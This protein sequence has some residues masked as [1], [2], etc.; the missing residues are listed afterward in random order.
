MRL[1]KMNLRLS[2]VCLLLPVSAAMA[3]PSLL[4]EQAVQPPLQVSLELP[5]KKLLR[6]RNSNKEG[7]DVVTG[8]FTLLPA[9]EQN[10]FPVE[11][12]IRGKSRR[13][14][15]RFPPLRLTFKKSDVKGS[16]LHGQ[17][18]LKLVTHCQENF[19]RR[20][21]LAA[22]M[23]AYRTLN[24]LTDM[25]FRVVA[26][27]ITYI[28][29][30]SGDETVQHAFL[31]EHKNKLAKRLQTDQVDVQQIKRGE[32]DENYAALVSMFQLL[33]GNTDFSLVSGPPE[34]ECCH[35][36]VVLQNP[37]TQKYHVVP[38]DFD[39]TGLVNP[40]YT[41]PPE[42]LGIKRFTQRKYRGY[43]LH[44][45]AVARVRQS[46]LQKQAE[47]LAGIETFDDIPNLNQKRAR[48]FLTKF[49]ALI[50]TDRAF[51]RHVLK[52]CR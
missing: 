28:D 37:Q 38:Y 5:L 10:T 16:I 9:S 48:S 30:D 44:N 33:I 51:Q 12:S 17:K 19:A 22:E 43:C 42:H 32:L 35:N 6:A 14:H 39:S 24:V 3:E 34:S 7:S 23:L 36:G 20:G 4:F 27:N 21:L 13:Q 29:T 40:P 46:L 1:L 15:C 25:S 8:A 45:E 18:R 26:L 2:L 52:A 31:I 11:V 47:I 41:T 50:D 49:F